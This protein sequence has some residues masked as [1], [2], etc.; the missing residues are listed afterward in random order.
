MDA[1]TD[2][3]P[4][5]GPGAVTQPEPTLPP[6]LTP[7]PTGWREVNDLLGATFCDPWPEG[8]AVDCPTGEAHFP[9]EAGCTTLGAA[10]PAGAFASGLPA[11]TVH[12]DSAA[13]PGGDGSEGSAF[14]TIAEAR[15]SLTGG[16]GT[17]AL[18]RGAYNEE[19]RV[20]SGEL[21]IVGACAAETSLT[22]T[23]GEPPRAIASA[24]G[25]ALTIRNLRIHGAE[26]GVASIV[27]AESLLTLEGVQIDDVTLSA[28]VAW[29]GGRLVARDSAF[30]D[31]QN[32]SVVDQTGRGVQLLDDGDITLERVVLERTRD[33][34]VINGRAAISMTDVAIRSVAPRLTS[35]K[36]RAIEMYGAASTTLTRVVIE[37]VHE[38]AILA[39]QVGTTLT[40]TDLVVR[41]VEPADPTGVGGRALEVIEAANATVSRA[42]FDEASSI[43]ITVSSDGVADLDDIIVSRTRTRVDD[44]QGRGLETWNGGSANLERAHFEANHDTSILVSG[45]SMEASDLT[46]VGTKSE[47]STGTRGSGL[48][49]QH[50]GTATLTRASLSGNRG[51]G[52]FVFGEG[53]LVTGTD[54]VITDTLGWEASGIGGVGVGAQNGS[55][56]T[57]TRALVQRNR[58]AGILAFHA[59]T[60]IT[61]TDITVLDTLDRDCVA[62]GV[63]EPNSGGFVAVFGAHI[64]AERFLIADGS[65]AGLQ[66][67]RGGEMDLTR[68][69]VRGHV[70]GAAVATE[71]FDTNRLTNDVAY[72]D[73]E[74]SLDT[75]SLP[76]PEIGDP[77]AE[78]EM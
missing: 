60:E 26:L 70:I 2:A 59:G 37:D 22:R 20:E 49:V 4:D 17:I 25:G 12:V 67:D 65:L 75:R 5:A 57:L 53:T 30:R 35:E 45:T 64:G 3:T 61:L 77:L 7:C 31:T 27:N 1:A 19:V 15:A 10:C 13:S 44:T 46:I 42:L 52:I 18:A 48:A 76:L 69:E 24:R 14:T 36:G 38:V 23:A 21:T 43:A 32:G 72:I 28:V 40:A 11:G 47:V 78:A 9:G 73:N 71:G 58:Q 55:A 39:G 62:T 56:L 68:G 8:G 16:S 34:A 51:H 41:R 54:V 66:L 33:V 50:E 63:C 29:D 6:T 74:T